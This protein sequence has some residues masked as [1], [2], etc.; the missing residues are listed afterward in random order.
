MPKVTIG[1]PVYNGELYIAHA[2]ASILAQ[3]FSDFELLIADNASVDRTVEICNRFAETD[4]RIRILPSDVNRGAAWNFNRLVKEARGEYFKWAAADDIC[5]P[6]FLSACVRVLDADPGVVLCHT[7]TDH[8]DK[9]GNVVGDYN[10]NMAVNATEPRRRF[11]DLIRIRHNCVSVF[12][13]IRTSILLKT[14]MIASYVASDRVLLAELALHGR[15]IFVEKNLF[16]RRCH[17]GN[18]VFLAEHGE[19]L[20]WFDTRLKGRIFFPNWRIMME[21]F[22][23]IWRSPQDLAEKWACHI[24]VL[25][26]SWERRNFLV[27]DLKEAL[28]RFLDRSLLGSWILLGLKK[29]S[30]AKIF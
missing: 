17:D 19:R 20:E 15:Q 26:N 4:G 10:W 3:T 16:Q 8:I 1:I 30:H 13:L 22:K 29:I 28:K 11:S 6:D 7:Y 23:V 27:V 9:D 5:L 24:I 14:N 25:R 21:L 2:I 12:G 18:S